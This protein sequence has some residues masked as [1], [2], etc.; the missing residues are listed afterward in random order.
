MHY[1]KDNLKISLHV[2]V[3]IRVL[4]VLQS[5]DGGTKS[6]SSPQIE[7]SRREEL[8]ISL[9]MYLQKWARLS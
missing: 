7:V 1:L 4:A 8:E 5:R 3:S 2:F 6:F 9:Q